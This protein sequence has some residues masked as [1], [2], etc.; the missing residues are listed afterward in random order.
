MY[1]VTSIANNASNGEVL[2][3]SLPKTLNHQSTVYCVLSAKH[4][5]HAIQT[6]CSKNEYRRMSISERF[7]ITSLSAPSEIYAVTLFDASD[8][9]MEPNGLHALRKYSKICSV[10]FNDQAGAIDRLRNELSSYTV[11]H[12]NFA[13]SLVLRDLRV[14]DNIQPVLGINFEG[15]NVPMP[16]FEEM[17]SQLK[18]VIATCGT[19][20]DILRVTDY[21][22]RECV[23][24]RLNRPVV[25]GHPQMWPLPSHLSE[26]LASASEFSNHM[27]SIIKNVKDMA[28][29]TLSGFLMHIIAFIIDLYDLFYNFSAAKISSML[30]RIVALV[31]PSIDVSYIKEL[32]ARLLDKILPLRLNT[33]DTNHSDKSVVD[34]RPNVFGHVVGDPTNLACA[35]VGGAVA[36]VM[37]AG[38]LETEDVLSTVLSAIAAFVGVIIGAEVISAVTIKSVLACCKGIT[39]VGATVRTLPML[40]STV[41][42]YL[43]DVI[44]GWVSYYC[45]EYVWSQSP[46]GIAYKQ[47]LLD[48]A[49]MT[50]DSRIALIMRNANDQRKVEDLAQQAFKFFE[51]FSSEERLNTIIAG[52]FRESM[53]KIIRLNNQVTEARGIGPRTEPFHVSVYGAPGIGKSHFA[54]AIADLLAPTEDALGNPIPQNMRVY[55]YTPGSTFMD[56][57][58]QQPVMVMDDVNQLATGEDAIEL[59]RFIGTT[60]LVAPM[61]SL[62]NPSIGVKGTRFV[63]KVIVSTTNVAYPT[64]KTVVSCDAVRRRRHLLLEARCKPEYF[65]GTKLDSTRLSA[66]DIELFKHL[67]VRTRDPLRANGPTGEWISV[68]EM[69]RS[70]VTQCQAHQ[71]REEAYKQRGFGKL[72][73]VVNGKP[74][75]LPWFKQPVSEKPPCPLLARCKDDHVLRGQILETLKHPVMDVAEYCSTEQ[76]ITLLALPELLRTH[77]HAHEHYETTDLATLVEAWNECCVGTEYAQVETLSGAQRFDIL[78]RRASAWLSEHMPLALSIFGCLSVVGV[79]TAI[80]VTFFKHESEEIGQPQMANPSNGET[81]QRKARVGRNYDR[82]YTILGR[83]QARVEG[84]AEEIPFGNVTDPLLDK[85]RSNVIGLS[86]S[87]AKMHAFS[88]GQNI[89]VTAGHFFKDM[90]PGELFDVILRGK[91]V[92]LVFEP[93]RLVVFHRRME[94]DGTESVSARDL[95]AYCVPFTMLPLFKDLRPHFFRI[96]E[97]N[98]YVSS[99]GVLITPTG[100]TNLPRV[101]NAT[102]T[103]RHFDGLYHIYEGLEY[104]GH[105]GVDGQCGLPIVLNMSTQ[106]NTSSVTRIGGIHTGSWGVSGYAEIITELEVNEVF[107]HFVHLRPNFQPHVVP[108]EAQCDNN[109]EATSAWDY[110]SPSHQLWTQGK[111]PKAVRLPTKHRYEPSPI[112]GMVAPP[113]TDNSVLSPFDERQ[114]PEVLGTSPLKRAHAKVAMGKKALPPGTIEDYLEGKIAELKSIFKEKPRVLTLDEAIN[115]IPGNPHIERLNLSTSPGF[116]FTSTAGK[117]KRHLFEE[118]TPGHFAPTISFRKVLDSAWIKLMSG[119]PLDHIWKATLKTERRKFEK[120]RLGKTRQFNVAQVVRILCSRRLNLHFHALLLE[121]CLQHSSTA[122]INCFSPQ[123]DQLAQRLLSYGCNLFDL[124]YETF[125]G[126]LPPQALSLRTQVANAIYDDDSVQGKLFRNARDALNYELCFR[127]D[128]VGDM[129]YQVYG[130]NPSGDDGTTHTNT[131]A[132]DFFLFLAWDIITR[133]DNLLSFQGYDA[134]RNN[135]IAS[136]LGD[137]NIVSVKDSAKN[138]YTPSRVCAILKRFNITATAASDA[139]G[140][141]VKNKQELEFKNL[142][143]CVFLKCGFDIVPSV[144]VTRVVPLMDWSTICELT[145]WKAV[146]LPD[147][148]AC[149]EN[150]NNALRMAFFHG[151]DKFNELRTKIV[152]ACASKMISKPE[153]LTFQLLLNCWRSEQWQEFPQTSPAKVAP[154][155]VSE[156]WMEN[157][158]WKHL[159]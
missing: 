61:A 81:L 143:N 85:F 146:G 3:L 107:E 1:Q 68:V 73:E 155:C 14:F 95:A 142:R 151:K 10:G 34:G 78:A 129:V 102:K 121:T 49:A 46:D 48:V 101:Q 122:G 118:D 125:D 134:F 11:L 44:K 128:I 57:Y 60:S 80:A 120:I 9:V 91:K 5:G 25:D 136:I 32:W 4:H 38:C 84:L 74:Q 65:D 126:S 137:D 116:G 27:D 147:E 156:L 145:N 75:Y 56:G 152:D 45:P 19:N 119:E 55:S 72:R 30:L 135:V 159:Q 18:R 115:G 77:W 69:M 39:I 88:P 83:P 89:I 71:D 127:Y 105:R 123:W 140:N 86:S 13:D 54:N 42:N 15:A 124:D 90:E 158:K 29:T 98:E 144:D 114:E 131:F 31:K 104:P 67:E 26:T 20:E 70:V 35:S 100:A 82:R 43:P 148:E 153:F 23:R 154:L 110:N 47:W 64:P 50:S 130:G 92:E 40:L 99:A 37:V 36:A 97:V 33:V 28:S 109:P 24:V 12:A 106:W 8:S 149:A 87:R 103:Y 17:F 16:A 117:G 108:G 112:M 94:V 2:D 76:Q 66:E 93:N 79:I 53:S 58:M 111:L 96:N 150:C 133:E 132:G 59:I 21:L 7:K 62:D 157:P 52:T 141:A 22:S 138:F 139:A 113:I 6:G 63:S 41:F 51:I